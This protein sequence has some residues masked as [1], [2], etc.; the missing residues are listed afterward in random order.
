MLSFCK[1]EAKKEP[2]LQKGVKTDHKRDGFPVSLLNPRALR[3]ILNKW[4][5]PEV[6]LP[7][8]YTLS[9]LPHKVAAPT[10]SVAPSPAQEYRQASENPREGKMS[11]TEAGQHLN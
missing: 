1:T 5:P 9:S 7:A 3:F 11:N 10:W 6:G 4:P 2:P 8:I